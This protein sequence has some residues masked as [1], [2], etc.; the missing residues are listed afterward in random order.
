[1]KEDK[2]PVFGKNK[3]IFVVIGIAV[4]AA[5][6]ITMVLFM[7]SK[8]YRLIKI[9]QV[10]G[11]AVLE[12]ENTGEMDA[13]ENLIMQKEDLLS[14]AQESD[15]R[16]QMDDDKYALVEENSILNIESEGDSENSKTNLVLQQGA[17][18]IEIQNKLSSGSTYHVTT[19]NA[20]M[21]VRGT[22]FR[23][24]LEKD[25]EGKSVTKITTLEGTVAVQKKA[26]DGT[27]SE[28]QLVEKGTQAIVKTENDEL[29]IQLLD[30]I[31]N[32]ELSQTAL[33]FLMEVITEDGKELSISRE[34]IDEIIKD[35]QL[36][37]EKPL[38]EKPLD[39]T[40]EDETEQTDAEKDKSK[41][42]N[43]AQNQIPKN[44]VSDNL[45]LKD[46]TP[47]DTTEEEAPPT[48]VQ[49][50]IQVSPDEKP[51]IY[52]VTFTY[53]G[54][55]FGTQKIASGNKAQ[56]PKLKP[57]VEGSWNFDFSTAITKDTIIKF[58]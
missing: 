17:V 34:T 11:S 1:M 13:Y 21:A 44:P 16:I 31:P 26:E 7:Q 20:V 43:T 49:G 14:V 33:E 6:V 4:V 58:E 9:Y 19:P 5:V 3:I 15:V 12:R 29:Q 10:N 41:E 47:Q 38:E 42:D 36:K 25:E 23:V 40:A 55:V 57:A 35:R 22:V 32:E 50:Q 51:E 18:T 54:K 2:A 56:K 45:G 53:E 48:V 39:E 28:E 27:F 37:E 24:A 46:T 52:T 30:E 8:G